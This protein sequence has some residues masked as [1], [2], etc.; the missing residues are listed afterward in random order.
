[1]KYISSQYFKIFKITFY[2]QRDFIDQ[3]SQKQPI[4]TNQ[5]FQSSFMNEDRKSLHYID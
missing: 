3:Y 5:L 2:K 4:L 1:M